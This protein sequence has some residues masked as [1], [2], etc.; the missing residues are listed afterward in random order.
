MKTRPILFKTEM[1]EAIL[2]DDKSETRRP[3]KMTELATLAIG[4]ITR[5]PV[6]GMGHARWADDTGNGW[7]AWCP[8]GQRGDLLWVRESC[9]I[10]GTWKRNGKTKTGKDAWRFDPDYMRKVR[11]DEPPKDEQCTKLE[12]P[13]PGWCHRPSI[14][15]PRWA[16]RLRLEVTYVRCQRIKSMN[17]LEAIAEGVTSTNFFPC[18]GYPLSVGYMLG[19]NDGKSLLYP[20]PTEAFRAGWE[21][22]HGAGA[23]NRN[24][25]VWVI[26]FKTDWRKEQ[27]IGN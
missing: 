2:R 17:D 3:V 10:L 20:E 8:Y 6:V 18:E 24:D 23:W 11:F 14:H 15:M 21:A 16:S 5:P 12:G 7:N 13:M 22:M 27:N 26:G 9:W 1:V 19:R 25:W 4:N